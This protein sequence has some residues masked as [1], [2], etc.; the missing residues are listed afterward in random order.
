MGIG[1]LILERIPG[2]SLD[3]VWNYYLTNEQK[4]IV[5]AQLATLYLQ[6]ESVTSP[7][8]GEVMVHQTGF[9]QGH[10]NVKDFMFLQP[11]GLPY[12]SMKTSK[13]MTLLLDR[14]QR[15]PPGLSVEVFMHA[16]ILRN[17]YHAKAE[18]LNIA[19]YKADKET[20]KS[21]VDSKL[22]GP[23]SDTSCLH[24]PDLHPGNIMVDFTADNI[25]VVTGV[26]DWDRASFVPRFATRVIPDWLLRNKNDDLTTDEYVSTFKKVIGYDW[27]TEAEDKLL[28]RARLLLQLSIGLW[29]PQPPFWIQKRHGFVRDKKPKLLRRAP[30]PCATSESFHYIPSPLDTGLLTE[31]QFTTIRYYAIQSGD[32]CGNVDRLY[33][34]MFGQ[35]RY[36]NP[37]L[38]SYCSKLQLG[39]A[40][41]AH[42]VSQPPSWVAR[43]W[44]ES[45]VEGMVI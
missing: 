27:T 22:F 39:V 9:I 32:Y 31:V 2:E 4:H 43:S 19:W 14:L 20:W 12:E 37:D 29:L 11:L 21:A 5:A 45:R 38:E 30:H 10:S 44:V 18:G 13:D 7:I 15:N 42:A 8:A 34:I 24:H 6:L 40:R 36:W 33:S 1:Y 16:A 35:L 23:K 25:P 17:L 28:A 26:I 3:E 41:C